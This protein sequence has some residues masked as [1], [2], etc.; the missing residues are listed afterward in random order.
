M[1]WQAPQVSMK[2][3]LLGASGHSRS[4]YC[5]CAAGIPRTSMTKG[6]ISERLPRIVSSQQL[7]ALSRPFWFVVGVSFAANTGA[8]K[9]GYRR[10]WANKPATSATGSSRLADLSV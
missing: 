5:A 6:I 9:N 2:R 8:V 7:T 10:R 3:A 1:S 4:V